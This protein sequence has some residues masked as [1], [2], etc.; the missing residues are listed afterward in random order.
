MI[1]H[2]QATCQCLGHDWSPWSLWS[3]VWPRVESYVAADDAVPG[4][5]PIPQR[6]CRDCLRC[7]ARQ[8]QDGEG[9]ITDVQEAR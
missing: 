6:R 5:E 3:A 9:H 1:T 7:G 2:R 8:T 4:L